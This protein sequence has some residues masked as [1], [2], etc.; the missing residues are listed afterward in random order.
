MREE[1]GD[2]RVIRRYGNR[3]LYDASQSRCVTLEEIA[4]FVRHGEDVRV[5]DSEN[6]ADITRRILTQIILEEPN[7]RRLEMLPVD[8]LRKIISMR[9]DNLSG[10][11]EQYLSAGAEWLER[12]MTTAQSAVGAK[13]MG[14]PD[15]MEA[16]FP[17]LKPGAT[18][19]DGPKPTRKAPPAARPAAAKPTA[20]KPTAAKIDRD[21]E[22]QDEITELQ[23][24]LAE[25]ASKVKRR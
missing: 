21:G 20:A 16:F 1:Y 6:G 7:Q 3:R 24:R 12:Q 9:D 18:A 19:D 14:L 13:G 25:L 22:V 11:L 2:A 15:S 5:I 17:W 10:W 4:D 23:R 8:L